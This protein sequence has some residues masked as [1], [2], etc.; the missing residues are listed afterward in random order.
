MNIVDAH[1]HLWD[2]RYLRYPL[3]EKMPV[4]NRPF[5][6]ADFEEVAVGNGVTQSVCVEAASAGVDGLAEI[7]WLL[8]QTHHSS[9]VTRLIAWAPIT[10]SDRRDY[11]DRLAELNDDRIVGIRR[12]FEFERPDFARHDD[13]IAGVKLAASYGYTVDLVFYHASLPAVIELVRA[14]PEV[15]FIVDHLGKPGIRQGL[16]DPWREH[17]AE[18]AQASNV[19]CKISGANTEADHRH[20]KKEDLKPYID[21][22]IQSFGWDRVMFGSDWPVCTLAG[23]YEQWLSALNW[24]INGAPEADRQK[25]FGD[26]AGRVYR[27]N[28]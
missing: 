20:W 15:Q 13:T 14:C 12:S 1:H 16:L 8:E 24:C 18:L 11:L 28:I 4:L 2:T 3:F 25:L 6:M 27:L 23:E 19:A 9:V 22:A 17:I 7:K 26:N 21:H 5:L 10:Q